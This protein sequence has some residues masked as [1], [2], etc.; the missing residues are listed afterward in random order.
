MNRDFWLGRRVLV[1]GH[2]GFKGSWLSLWLQRLGAQVAGI[3]L[4]PLTSPSLFASAE[5]AAGME[6][7]EGDVRDL[8][9]LT[10]TFGAHRPE[11]VFH[12]AAQALVR[13]SYDSPVDTY[14][15]NVMGTV[16]VLEAARRAG[17]VRALV[18]VTS[19]K[20][21]A[22]R[23]RGHGYA[24]AEPMGGDDPYSSSKACAELV[25]AAFT[26]SFFPPAEYATHGVAVATARAG[27]VIGGGDWAT[28]R[29]IPDIVRALTS[30]LPVVIRNPAA[31]RPWQH[32]LEPLKGYLDLAEALVE[33]GPEF[34]GG[35]NFGPDPSDERPVSWLV[36]RAVRGW[37]A[38]ARWELDGRTHPHEA[39]TLKLD[40]TKARKLLGWSPVLGLPTTLDS[41][42]QWYRTF[43][44]C[45]DGGRGSARPLAVREISCYEELLPC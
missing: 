44:R 27:N 1:T 37:G 21:Y 34:S 14:S 23:E 8:A 19:D 5:I 24:E 11:V 36:E 12:L 43:Y 17:G 42:I 40:C 20:C 4:P 13:A 15:T 31:V 38:G 6:S 41:V 29:L 2:T 22:N 26:R 25:T 33:R 30:G 16:N 9:A 10:E 7:A 18:I 35:W 28:D 3:G 45:C 32:V 39:T